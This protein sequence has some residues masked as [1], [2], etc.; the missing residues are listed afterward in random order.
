MA[1]HITII[2]T[3]AR[4]CNNQIIGYINFLFNVIITFIIK[5]KMNLKRH[6]SAAYMGFGAVS[7]TASFNATGSASLRFQTGY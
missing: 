5:I 4:D 3:A 2:L 1:M 6:S 7:T